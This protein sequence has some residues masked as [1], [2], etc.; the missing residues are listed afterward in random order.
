MQPLWLL[1][2]LCAIE[3][4]N[5]VKNTVAKKVFN[6]KVKQDSCKVMSTMKKKSCEIRSCVFIQFP[7]STFGW[8]LRINICQI[9]T[10]GHHSLFDHLASAS[11]H[12][13]GGPRNR[14]MGFWHVAL[15]CEEA[16]KQS[17]KN[18]FP[19]RQNNG[20][21]PAKIRNIFFFFDSWSFRWNRGLKGR[22][23]RI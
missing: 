16:R 8:C 21:M 6:V 17:V 13:L 12:W 5:V 2:Y 11:A 20:T 18:V 3:T 15:P 10:S 23:S 9:S 19:R 1:W 22:T 14:F 7:K 4:G